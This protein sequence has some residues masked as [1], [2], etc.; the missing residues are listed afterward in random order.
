MNDPRVRIPQDAVWAEVKREREELRAEVE[1]L[2]QILARSDSDEEARLRAEVE[3]L[4]GQIHELGALGSREVLAHEQTKAEV[5]RL[6]A[7]IAELEAEVTSNER[8]W[9]VAEERCAGYLRLT[10]AV[11]S[12]RDELRAEVARLRAALQR[13]ADQDWAVRP[14]AQE[15][16]RIARA[17]L[18]R[19]KE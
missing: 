3:R 7:R 5:D 10:H 1:R 19:P 6:E 4:Q 12:E 11:H 13:I 2:K 16:R 17:A 18:V 8:R 15:F 9:Q 14:D